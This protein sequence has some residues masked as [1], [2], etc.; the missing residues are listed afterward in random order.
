M[1]PA[2]A[3]LQESLQ[4][5]PLREGVKVKERPLMGVPSRAQVLRSAWEQQR[6]VE[7]DRMV[8]LVALMVA[9]HR[10]A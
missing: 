6:L 3:L 8:V 10:A 7:G 2:Q 9:A 4:S 1:Q 5:L